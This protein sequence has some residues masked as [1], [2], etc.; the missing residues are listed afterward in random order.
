M[1]ILLL[2]LKSSFSPDLSCAYDE[3]CES[4]AHEFDLKADSS[5]PSPFIMEYN[6]FLKKIA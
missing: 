5:S 1:F 2:S 4:D 3:S 6:R